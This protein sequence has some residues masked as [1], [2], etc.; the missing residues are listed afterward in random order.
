[1]TTQRTT[2]PTTTRSAGTDV[3]KSTSVPSP[4]GP[5]TVV[6]SDVGVRAV[7]WP[8]DDPGRVPLDGAAADAEHPVLASAAAQLA[9][10][11]DG[12][13]Q[14]FDLPLDP[15]GTEASCLPEG[16]HRVL[17]HSLHSTAVTNDL[18]LPELTT[19]HPA[20]RAGV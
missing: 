14:D 6:A 11:F 19:L 5:L 8:S 15:V 2:D 12:T 9:E 16:R 1:M 17:G 18:H 3:L 10:Y 4:V 13:R 7:L 20:T